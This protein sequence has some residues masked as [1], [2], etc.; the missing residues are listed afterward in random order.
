MNR[1]SLAAAA[2][3]DVSSMHGNSP[4][5]TLSS[6]SQLQSGITNTSTTI[7]SNVT[8]TATWLEEAENLLSKKIGSCSFQTQI[9]D[10]MKAIKNLID[11]APEILSLSADLPKLL[12]NNNSIIGSTNNNMHQSSNPT[13]PNL[14]VQNTHTGGKRKLSLSSTDSPDNAMKILASL[15]SQAVPVPINESNSGEVHQTNSPRANAE[16]AKTFVNF[17][18][19]VEHM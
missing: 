13:H 9:E 3:S 18:Q 5:Y 14:S 10:E 7:E 8:K 1:K 2:V 17:L 12:D 15:S 4:L 11:R 16:D 6:P 19:S